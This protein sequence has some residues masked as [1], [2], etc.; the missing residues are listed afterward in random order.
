MKA[1]Q[2]EQRQGGAGLLIVVAL[3]AV[4][5]AGRKKD[6]LVDFV[7]PEITVTPITPIPVVVAPP[8]VAPVV[9]APVIPPRVTF[10]DATIVAY[11]SRIGF[12]TST[13]A[14]NGVRF[15]LQPTSGNA[16]FQPGGSEYAI[17]FAIHLGTQAQ[18]RTSGG[19]TRRGV[20][21]ITG[22][23]LRWRR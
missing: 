20:A 21:P 16:R 7:P 6:Q 13:A 12:S 5:L 11:L 19:R 17:L 22:P 3:A 14:I 10:T 8:V 9:V 23:G 18:L 15:Q 1:M 4:L 2:V